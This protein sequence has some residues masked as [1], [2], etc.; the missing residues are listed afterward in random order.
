MSAKANPENN[1]ARDRR[2][3]SDPGRS[4]MA[5]GC[6][7]CRY[8]QVCGGICVEES[9]F[10]CQAFCC[11][12]PNKC[13]WVCRRRTEEFP[14][15][16]HEI[17]GFELSNIPVVDSVPVAAM[18]SVITMIEHGS[19][20]TARHAAPW[21]AVPLRELFDQ[22]SGHVRFADREAFDR[23]FRLAPGAHV[24]ASGVGKDQP[25]ENLWG[26]GRNRRR[27]VMRGLR[28]LGIDLVTTPNFSLF[29][30]VPREDAM[31]SMK[32]IAW[33][34][35]ELLEEGIGAALHV[36]ASTEHDYA[37]WAEF[38]VAHL[39]VTHIATEFKTGTG[40]AERRDWHAL[41]LALLLMRVGRPLHLVT[42]NRME[43][44][45][46][47][48]RTFM[49]RISVIDTTSFMATINRQVAARQP[50]GAV[51]LQE[52]PLPTG[53]PLDQRLAHNASLYGSWVAERMGLA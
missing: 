37:R 20:R 36:N 5:L 10:D 31:Y 38:I 45:P 33:V 53:T 18:P 12:T 19:A 51:V 22:R 50:D 52:G 40:W 35:S 16:V 11:R 34:F 4:S 3:W 2:L 21:V 1:Y 42:R 14:D 41:Q 15:F 49:D 8:L 28:Q 48:A 39:E 27:V 30:D 17:E 43:I 23:H 9:V 25:I 6:T 7:G 24:V 47:L 32:R 44:L 26:L 13:N 29:T 46:V